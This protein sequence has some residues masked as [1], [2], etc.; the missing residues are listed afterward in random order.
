MTKPFAFLLRAKED[1]WNLKRAIFLV[2]IPIF[3]LNLTEASFESFLGGEGILL[4]LV[5]GAAEIAQRSV[6]EKAKADHQKGGS[7]AQSL[8]FT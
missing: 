4:G 1:P 7:L 6:E 2:V 8:S 3:I 5:W